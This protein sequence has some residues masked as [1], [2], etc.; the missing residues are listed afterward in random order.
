MSILYKNRVS[1]IN[2][3]EIVECFGVY[4]GPYTGKVYILYRFCEDKRFCWGY[5]VPQG[6]VITGDYATP[7]EAEEDL[8]FRD[9]CV[10]LGH[11]FPT[12]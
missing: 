12:I 11:Q 9:K 2:S 7:E 5:R 4:D 3:S 8:A 1:P 10:A 6:V